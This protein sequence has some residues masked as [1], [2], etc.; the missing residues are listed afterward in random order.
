MT[1]NP[2]TVAPPSAWRAW[3]FLVRLSFWR[4][5]RL[6]QMVWVALG[7]L[8]FA[9]ALVAVNTALDRWNIR[10]WT[11]RAYSMPVGQFTDRLE[12]ALLA[13]PPPS[14]ILLGIL[15]TVQQITLHSPFPFI[16]YTQGV[17]TGLF[18]GFLL[19][20]WTLSFA[21]EAL[22]GEREQNNLLWLLSR[23]LD[24]RAI[25]LAKF[26]ALL[27]WTLAFNLGG[28]VLLCLA[29]GAPGRLALALFW[30]TV[31]LATLAFAALF[32]LLAASFRRAT[33]LALVYVF[34]LEIIL[35][36]MPGYLKWATIGFYARCMMLQAGE[37]YGLPQPRADLFVPVSATT[38]LVVLSV[39]TIALLALG[40]VIFR[41]SQYQ[42]GAA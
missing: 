23:P 35:N 8:V 36:L 9:T 29:G 31:L 15:E 19:P 24:R 14:P 21:T 10:A 1:A 16:V 40:A 4:Q 12:A 6:R 2:A 27:P 42:D 7:L 18:L 28:F 13:V 39:M 25:Y 34:F 11:A 38:A 22:G 41:R 37:P 26:V 32:H 33:I 17:V 30:P 20:L 3:W 5:A